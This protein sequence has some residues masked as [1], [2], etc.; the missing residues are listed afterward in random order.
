M[1]IKYFLS[2]TPQGF[3]TSGLAAG[4]V[5]GGRLVARLAQGLVHYDASL[6]EHRYHLLGFALTSAGPGEVV[7]VQRGGTA[8]YAGLGLPDNSTLLAGREGR[9]VTSDQGLVFRQIVGK[10]IGPDQFVYA[11]STTFLLSPL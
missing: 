10:S 7:T 1:P 8:Y 11:P 4:N 9:L 6:I 5:I 2:N 3:V